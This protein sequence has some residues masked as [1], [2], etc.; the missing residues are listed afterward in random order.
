VWGS[1][2]KITG[3]PVTVIFEAPGE[4]LPLE[5]QA[6]WNQFPAN[7]T[8]SL[9]L[10]ETLPEDETPTDPLAG[11][12]LTIEGALESVTGVFVEKPDFVGFLSGSTLEVG[13][14]WLVGQMRKIG[15]QVGNIVGVFIKVRIVGVVIC[16][17]GV[18]IFNP[19]LDRTVGT[20]W[21]NAIPFDVFKTGIVFVEEE[22]KLFPET[23][24]EKRNKIAS[25]RQSVSPRTN[26]V[27][28]WKCFGKSRKM[29]CINRDF[30]MFFHALITVLF[31][32]RNFTA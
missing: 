1:K 4:K 21:V 17:T 22:S 32:N 20:A 6:N 29:F 27:F 8:A 30:F 13:S 19:P 24:T 12:M 31:G 3:P 11:A 10:S 18:S 9:K 16:G 23:Y 14:I 15:G 5:E 28:L 7:V 2:E 26:K 25:K